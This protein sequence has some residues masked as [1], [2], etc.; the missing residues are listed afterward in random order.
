VQLSPD[1]REEKIRPLAS[2]GLSTRQI[3]QATG[4]PQSTVVRDL[5][6]INTGENPVML[7][8]TAQTPKRLRRWVWP[9]A[10]SVTAL[11]VLAVA[12]CSVTLFREIPGRPTVY[13]PVFP[14]P[15]QPAA[16]EAPI[17]LCVGLTLEGY[18]SDIAPA[19]N[20]KCPGDWKL[21]VLRPNG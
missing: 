3:E 19:M 17:Y 12:F 5:K 14:A 15:A 2:A 6:R 13:A 9:I 10:I 18:V 20:R 4:I 1:E 8:E 11:L 21:L 16:V 7:P